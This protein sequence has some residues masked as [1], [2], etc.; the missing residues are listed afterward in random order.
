MA[1]TITA[2][3]IRTEPDRPLVNGDRNDDDAAHAA[4]FDN[5]DMHVDQGGEADGVNEIV[6]YHEVE[7]RA[8]TAHLPPVLVSIS[9]P[10]LLPLAAYFLMYPRHISASPLAQCLTF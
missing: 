5:A 2:A 3:R 10:H 7:P 9:L 6:Q 8:R 1:T 4:R